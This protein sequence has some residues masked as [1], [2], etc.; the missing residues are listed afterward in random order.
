[1]KTLIVIPTRDRKIWVLFSVLISFFFPSTLHALPTAKK[2]VAG[3]A[4]FQKSLDQTTLNVTASDRSIIE[5]ES[6]NVASHETVNFILPSLEAVSLSRIVGP[7]TSQIAGRLNANGK[8]VLVNLGGFYFSPTARV[9]VGKI[10]AST[11]GITNRDFLKGSSVFAGPESQPAP[12][13]TSILNEGLI[14]TRE[15]GAAILIAGVIEN[16][17]VI[18]APHGAVALYGKKGLGGSRGRKGKKVKTEV[19]VY[20]GLVYVE[21]NLYHLGV[22]VS[23]G[24]KTE[25]LWKRVPQIPKRFLG[26]GFARFAFVEIG[27]SL[28]QIEDVRR[29][30]GRLKNR[31]TPD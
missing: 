1:M 5:W 28:E 18:E 23:A 16:P 9:Q 6:L 20:E 22:S 30:I 19:H 29:K 15:G 24:M 31:P 27:Y 13:L 10:T 2:V 17:G 12:P 14:H 7:G 4:S 8:L 3:S 11:R 26:I 21:E 25:V